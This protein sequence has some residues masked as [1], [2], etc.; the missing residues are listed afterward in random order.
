MTQFVQNVE[1]TFF[2][3]RGETFGVSSFG[4]NLVDTPGFGD[5]D[6]LA[7]AKNAH[8]IAFAFQFG[9][10][11]IVLVIGKAE[12]KLKAPVQSKLLIYYY[13]SNVTF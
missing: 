4:L 6:P 3:G 5:S 2:G 1:S 7:L 10:H 11:S 13:C 9:V 12:L 8:R